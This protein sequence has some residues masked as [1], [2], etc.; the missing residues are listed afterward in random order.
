MKN[1]RLR[2]LVIAHELSP[3]NGSECAEGWNI[4]TRLAQFHNVTVFYASGSHGNQGSYL[5]DV[6]NY[7]SENGAIDGLTFVNIDQPGMTNFFVKLNKPFR[8][9]NPSIGLP[10]LY[11]LGY[12]YWQKAA[13]TRAKQFHK[14]EKF[15]VVHQLTQITFR[16]PGYCWKL[17]IPFFWGP[18]GGTKSFPKEFHKLLSKKSRILEKVRMFSNFYQFNFSSKVIKANKIAS[19][20]YTYST[21]DAGVLN[22]RATGKVKLMLDAGTANHTEIIDHIKPGASVIKGIWCGQLN[23]RKAAVLLLEAIALSNL[24]KEKVQFQIVGKGP[25]ENALH[26]QSKALGLTNIEWVRHVD[27][28]TIFKMMSEADFLVHTSIREGTPHVIPEA[29]S[30]GIPVICHDAFGMGVAIN[31]ECGIKVPLVSPEVSIKGFQEAMERLVLNKNL[32]EKL[33][34]G[35]INRAHELS[36]NKMAETISGDYCAIINNTPGDL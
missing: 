25:L 29:L 27:R 7:I 21:A 12:K 16:E 9:F 17:N 23:E 34:T 22:K 10:V 35:A 3:K 1:E 15:D 33:K 19:V 36:W 18:T 28:N 8:K 4:V 14:I 6:N 26:E 31:D 30:T 32:L 11:F 2:V 13:F 24:I 20:I 5:K